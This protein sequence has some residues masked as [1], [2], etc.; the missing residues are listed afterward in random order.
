MQIELFD[1]YKVGTNLITECVKK[2]RETERGELLKYF[3]ENININRISNKYKPVTISRIGMLLSHLNI[4]ELYFLKS[5]CNDAGNR[6]KNYHE[7]FSKMF[8][9]SIKVQK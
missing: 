1:K 9:W 7:S 5:T 2:S 3:Q 4:P 8:Y 6:S